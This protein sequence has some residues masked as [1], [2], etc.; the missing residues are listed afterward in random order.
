MVLPQ[1]MAYATLAGLPVQFGLYVALAPPLAYALLGSSR[2]LSVSTTSTQT[3]VN[4]GSGAQTR[5]SGAVTS[6][7]AVL[8][9]LFLTGLFAH[10]ADAT[11]G[12]VVL[13]AILISLLALMRTLNAMPIRVLG[14]DPETGGE[15]TVIEV[16]GDFDHRLR[17][18][19]MELWLRALTDRSLAMLRQIPGGHGFDGRLFRS[20]DEAV[21]KFRLVTTAARA[22]ASIASPRLHLQRPPSRAGSASHWPTTPF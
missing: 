13:V 4:D 12:A 6:V 3:A 21:E 14:R 1:A 16:L 8:V 9:L 22:L 15:V 19:G 2:A 11:L 7:V 17:R 18:Q 5:L 10:L 20:V